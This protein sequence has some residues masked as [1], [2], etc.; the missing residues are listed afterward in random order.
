MKLFMREP[1]GA[2]ENP[3]AAGPHVASDQGGAAGGR[4][5]T[6]F[7]SLPL[8]ILAGNGVESMTGAFIKGYTQI[9]VDIEEGVRSSQCEALSADVILFPEWEL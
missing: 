5:A 8:A 6:A 3:E 2:S 7:M 9:P 1:K 4:L